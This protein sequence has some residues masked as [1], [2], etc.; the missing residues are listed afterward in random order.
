[1]SFEKESLKFDQGKLPYFTVLGTQFPLAIKE[2]VRRSL[3][4]H[5]KYEKGDDW[6]NWFRLAEERGVSSY[7]NALL[8]HLFR[9]GEDSELGHDVAVAWNAVARLEYKLRKKMY[10]KYDYR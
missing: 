9:D 2:V 10:K 7:D 4:G 6:E 1:M 3:E 8:R 5:E